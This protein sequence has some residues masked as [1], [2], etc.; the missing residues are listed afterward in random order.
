M[1]SI[2]LHRVALVLPFA[3]FLA[4]IGAPVERVF[5]QVGVPYMA[6]E[7]VNNYVPTRKF[8]AFVDHMARSEGIEDLGFRVGLT[9]GANCADPRMSSLLCKSPT[10]HHAITTT[11]ALVRKTVSRSRILL[12]RQPPGNRF[13]L[14]HRPSFAADMPF[15]G[16]QDW[17]GLMGLLDIVR[18]FTG[19]QWQPAEIGVT[20]R[21]APCRS[22][23]EQ[24]PHTRILTSQPYAYLSLDA[25]L[26]CQPPISP[27][28]ASETQ[29][30]KT[31]P[32]GFV[33][34]LTEALRACLGEQELSI[35]LATDLCGMSKRSLQRKLS[36]SD[37]RFSELVDRVRFDAASDLLRDPDVKVTDVANTLGYS[38]SAHFAR[39]FRRIAGVNPRAY[40]QQHQN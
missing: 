36:A 37:T 32:I 28:A 24:L 25:D 30:H 19:P 15:S 8:Y 16:Q 23:Q 1:Q 33:A 12:V 7:D 13:H 17:F 5:R 35:E 6:L 34:E 2:P 9:Y 31:V 3:R 40:R 21:H 26:L 22:I 29:P 10:L 4:D 38:D 18:L 20:I 14:G 11:S 27:T 39:A